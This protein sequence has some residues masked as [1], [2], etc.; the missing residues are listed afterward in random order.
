MMGTKMRNFTTLPEE[1]W[2]R[3]WC[4]SSDARSVIR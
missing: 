3:T 1:V 2:R 4:G